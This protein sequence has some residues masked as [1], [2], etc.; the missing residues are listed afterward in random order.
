MLGVI[1]GSGLYDLGGLE[2]REW[3]GHRQPVGRAFGRDPVRGVGR[4]CPLRFLP[5][6]G[7][8]HPLSPTDINY[9]ANIDALK[10]SGVTDLIS[11]SACGSLKESLPPGAIV[12]VDQFIDRTVSRDRSFFGDGCVAHVSMADPVSPGLLNLLQGAAAAENIAAVR[13][14]N[15]CRD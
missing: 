11:V 15:L 14:G 13:G 5:R 10:R 9:R 4:V 2:F 1:G 8:G 12:L 3:R 6:H 7:R